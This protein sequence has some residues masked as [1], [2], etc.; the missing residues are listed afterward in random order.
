MRARTLEPTRAVGLDLDAVLAVER[1]EAACGGRELPCRSERTGGRIE[2]SFDDVLP[3]GTEFEVAVTYA[4]HPREA[5]NPPWRGGFTWAETADGRPWIATSCQGEGADLWWPCKD[6]PSDKAEGIDLEVTIPKEL[7]CASNGVLVSDKVVQERRTQHWRTRHPISNYGLALNIAPYQVLQASID[8][9]GGKAFPVYFWHLPESAEKARAAFPEFLDHL[10]FFE[11]RLGPYPFRSEKYGIAETPHLGMEHPTVIAYGNRFRGGP[12]GFDWLHHHELA[13]EW[14]G[15]LVTCRDW[16]D[17]WLHEG[18]GTY[19]Q[20]LYAEERGG[21]PALGRFMAR[22]RAELGNTRPVAPRETHDSQAI[23]F[24]ER[25]ESDSDIY[26]KGAWALHT[27]RWHMGD[28]AFFELLRRFAYPDPE[29]LELSPTQVRFAD[30]EELLALA[31]ELHGE[32]LGWFFEVY[33][34]QSELPRLALAQAGDEL[35][36][37]WSVPLDVPFPLD[38]P[39]AVDGRTLRVEVDESG[40]G[41]THA[42]HRFRADPDGWLLKAE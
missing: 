32:D 2:L 20:A 25:G 17:M 5:P 19:M 34:R 31:E 38:V 10:M 37:T 28:S 7:V 8:S 39:V 42:G 40:R 29:E 18:F 26:Y 21:Q 30:T 36:V 15:N 24:G 33:L 1:V 3:A 27:L 23:Y 14:W 4:G 41:T 35:T 13:H 11:D 22:I 9:I 6:H 16:K 12:D